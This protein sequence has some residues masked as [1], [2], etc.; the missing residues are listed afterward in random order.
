MAWMPPSADNVSPV[1]A[2]EA[3]DASRAITGEIISADGGI[4]ATVNLWPTV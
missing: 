1:I 3:S 4:H 2:L